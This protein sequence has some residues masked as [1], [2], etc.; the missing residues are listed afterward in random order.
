MRDPDIDRRTSSKSRSA[1]VRVKPGLVNL[2]DIWTP[3]KA[4]NDDH[5]TYPIMHPFSVVPVEDLET[6]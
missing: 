2:T 1:W 5:D 4:I 6:K 3:A